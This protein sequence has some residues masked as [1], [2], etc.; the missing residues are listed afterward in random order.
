MM[1]RRLSFSNLHRKALEANRLGIDLS[2]RLLKRIEKLLEAYDD[3][4]QVQRDPNNSWISNTDVAT[5][6]VQNLERLYGIDLLSIDG[7]TVESHDA[8][9]EFLADCDP[10]QVFDVIQLWNDELLPDRQPSLQKDLN[11]IFEEEQSPWVF[12]DRDFFQIDSK[13]L[14]EKVVAQTHELLTTN[15]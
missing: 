15:G 9:H 1:N 13:F 3:P 4:L 11:L 2:G 7:M 6:V 12:C 8:V 5:E 10:A 14:H